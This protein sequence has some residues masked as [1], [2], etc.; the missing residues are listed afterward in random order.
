MSIFSSDIGKE[1]KRLLPNL[2]WTSFYHDGETVPTVKISNLIGPKESESVFGLSNDLNLGLLYIPKGSTFPQFGE[3]AKVTMVLVSCGPGA[4][5]GPTKDFLG[6]VAEGQVM[7][8][9]SAAPKVI[10]VSKT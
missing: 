1:I 9:P 10:V 2:T 4:K 6:S 3:E 7:Y 8:Y 5:V